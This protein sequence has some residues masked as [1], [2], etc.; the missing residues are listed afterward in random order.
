M[1]P[2][3]QEAPGADPPPAE[4]AS[5][6]EPEPS[7]PAD[8][9]AGAPPP[10]AAWRAWVPA[11][12]AVALT[13]AA[14]VAGLG[15]RST[16]LGTLLPVVG[17][18]QLLLAATACWWM[19]R[20]GALRRELQPRSGDVTIG[21]AVALVLY[22]GAVFGARIVAPR[23]SMREWWLVRIYL[24]VGDPVLATGLAVAL[25]VLLVGALEELVWRGWVM[26]SLARRYGPWRGWLWSSALYALAYLP[27]AY[28][29]REPAAGL[30]P[31]VPLGAL[32]GGLVWGFAATRAG[33][34]AP[35]AFA[36]GLLVWGLCE[37]PLWRP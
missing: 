18:T 2:L 16:G 23:G 34:L 1:S 3:E 27:A 24:H 8:G 22:G 29:L 11:A 31:L 17:G 32:V 30:N 20:R 9:G 36:H 33:R 6:H 19:W 10:L 25:A 21:F 26:R 28:L 35:A 7:S 13:G 12:T 37:Y 5:A 15:E 4:P 14:L